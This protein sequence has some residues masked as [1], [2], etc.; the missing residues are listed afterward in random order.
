M[1]WSTKNN[2]SSGGKDLDYNDK[3]EKYNKQQK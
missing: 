2:S 3:G 1:S